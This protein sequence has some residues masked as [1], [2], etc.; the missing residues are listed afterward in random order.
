MTNSVQAHCFLKDHWF[1]NIIRQQEAKIILQLIFTRPVMLNEAAKTRP[2]R[3]KLRP[4]L[5]SKLTE[6]KSLCPKYSQRL[7]TDIFVAQYSAKHVI[8]WHVSVHITAQSPITQFYE[9]LL[10]T[11]RK[12]RGQIQMLKS[13]LR[14]TPKFRPRGKW[15]GLKILTLLDIQCESKN[16]SCGFLTFFPNGWEFFNQFL[17]TH[18][19]FLSA[20]DYKFLFNYLQLWRSYAILSAT[21]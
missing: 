17:H 15:S 11:T 12:N 4:I 8:R 13:R 5:A 20:L 6:N 1:H 21:T 18:R 10:L 19:T 7:W 16:P 9:A 2:M 14:P 3:Q